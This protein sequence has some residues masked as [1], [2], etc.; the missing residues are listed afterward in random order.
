M[1]IDFPFRFDTRGRTAE[2][3]DNDHIR[4]LIEQVLFTSAGERVNRPDF[5]S[6]LQRMVFAPNSDELAAATQF[7]VQGS[8]QQ[9][10]GDLIEVNEVHVESEDSK[11]L[12]TI[13][14]TVR[15]TQ[16]QRI[17]QFT[18]GGALS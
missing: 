18:R 11:L 2:T 10:L 8:L 16:Q 4:D 9:W 1:N 15:R 7:L 12:V 5:G 14:Y 3:D 13:Q 6:G 17:E